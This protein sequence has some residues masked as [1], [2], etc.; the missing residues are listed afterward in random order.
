MAA[1]TKG[2]IKK[3]IRKKFIDAIREHRS[4][5]KACEAVG[6]G[7]T[8]VYRWRND[9]SE[10]QEEWDEAVETNVDDLE[11]GAMKRAIEGWLEPVYFKG[12]PVGV[13]RKFSNALTIFMLKKNRKK[14]YDDIGLE[15][16][17]QQETIADETF[18]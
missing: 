13:V 18:L 3:D 7:R 5:T 12:K 2:T 10:F 4:I 6:K 11:A 9:D 14:M 16:M 17:D 15:H 1:G 8:T